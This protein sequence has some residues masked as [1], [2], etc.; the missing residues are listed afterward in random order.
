MAGRGGIPP[1][2]ILRGLFGS[3]VSSAEEGEG[4]A[5]VW[6]KLRTAA[7][8][9]ATSQLQAML[10]EGPSTEAVSAYVSRMM[11]G[12]S[13]SMVSTY[14]GL[15]GQ[16]VAA[17]SNLAQRD[18]ESQIFGDAI[19]RAPWRSTG[20]GTGQEERFRIRVN[21]DIQYAGFTSVQH[22]E[23]NTYDLDGPLTSVADALRSAK[24][25]F[26][27]ATYNARASINGVLDY[28]IEVV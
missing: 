24:D 15:A 20:P 2:N 21:W 22:S 14:R 8:N 4:T 12:I 5:A 19:W 7:A 6:S 28:S 23:W 16:Y 13:A 10:G 11:S 9:W 27:R 18:P 1:D 3:L 25:A 17:K 26:E